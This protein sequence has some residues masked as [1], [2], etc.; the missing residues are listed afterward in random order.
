MIGSGWDIDVNAKHD[1]K[2]MMEG[3]THFI[4]QLRW[5]AKT[6]LTLNAIKYYNSLATFVDP[7]TISLYNPKKNK[8][9]TVTAKYILVGTGG[10]PTYP[11]DVEGAK[12]NAITSDD[13]FYLEKNPGKTLIVG[14]SYIALETAGFLTGIGNDVT[15][16]VRSILL[17][18]FD[19]EV[20]GRIGEY[21][22]S[23]GTKF[24]NKSVP[25]SIKKLENG[26]KRVT[27]K[28]LDDGTTKEE[29]FD[30]VLFA[31]G[32]TA[33]TSKLNLDKAG[34]KIN[35]K[36]QKIITNERDETSTP[37]I[38]ALGD[39]ADG[40]PELT[41]PAVMAGKFL[42]RRLFGDSKKLMDYRN[43]ATTVFTPLEYGS[44]GYTEEE[45]QKTFG[46]EKVIGY[47]NIFKPIEWTFNE[48]RPNAGYVKIVCRIEENGDETVL[49][50]H[51]LG[52]NA[53]E[54]IQGFAVSVKKGITR[55]EMDETVG[56]H[57][58]TAEEMLELP[59]RTD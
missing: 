10:R 24:I 47:H 46:K 49:G 5:N 18:G 1:W 14:A 48:E 52:P 2:K 59:F 21:M 16:L 35:P 57:P 31:I 3:A 19:Q 41:P 44:V 26:Q 55:E 8:T 7:H 39:V 45:A 56:I 23:Q 15:V 17:R 27:Y 11:D 4:R 22:K 38:F 13:I 25:V 58:T 50:M 33:N 54:V 53:G 20:A 36:N 42:S 51:Y 43:V 37:H 12:E 6:T 29:D 32:R 34:V 30:T 28:N 9:E 40:K